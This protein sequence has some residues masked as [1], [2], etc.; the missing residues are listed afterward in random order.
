MEKKSWILIAIASLS[1]SALFAD[2]AVAPQAA[3]Q[4]ICV[5]V[6]DQEQKK[7]EASANQEVAEV[8]APAEVQE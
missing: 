1:A 3:D 5:C 7:D 8:E 4:E 6:D 2:E